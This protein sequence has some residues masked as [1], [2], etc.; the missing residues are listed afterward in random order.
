MKVVADRRRNAAK[1]LIDDREL[2]GADDR[3]IGLAGKDGMSLGVGC[4][5]S[6]RIV[7]QDRLVEKIVAGRGAR[8]D[9]ESDLHRGVATPR[10]V[11]RPIEG[12]LFVLFQNQR[13]A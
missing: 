3:D 10:K 1:G 2:S 12:Q 8:E 9:A 13:G 5:Y 6:P 7:D 11:R 4:A